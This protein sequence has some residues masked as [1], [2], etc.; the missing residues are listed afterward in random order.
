MDGFGV[1]GIA[2][3]FAAVHIQAGHLQ[4]T[5][6]LLFLLL[7]IAIG[8]AVLAVK[9]GR[10]VPFF[11]TAGL[12]AA[13]AIVAA[14]PHTSQLALTEQYAEFTTRGNR[15][16]WPN[17]MKAPRTDSTAGTCWNTACRVRSG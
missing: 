6:Y 12:L 11:K 14:L 15:I 4:M 5:Y 10:V 17:R 9:E 7:A 2:S 1:V 16:S 3:L 13:G 8:A